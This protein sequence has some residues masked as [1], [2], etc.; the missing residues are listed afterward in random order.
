MARGQG[1]GLLTALQRT[2]VN[3]R[4]RLILKQSGDTFG[5]ATPDERQRAVR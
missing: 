5:L 1:G 4:Q 3:R 2:G